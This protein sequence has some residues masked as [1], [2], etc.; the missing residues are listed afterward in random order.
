[1]SLGGRVNCFVRYPLQGE[2]KEEEDVY[3]EVDESEYAKRVQERLQDDWIVDDG[4]QFF[5]IC[6]EDA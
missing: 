2:T 4:M 6:R 3:D 5:L 1:M